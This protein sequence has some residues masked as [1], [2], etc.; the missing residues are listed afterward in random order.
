MRCARSL[1]NAAT[2]SHPKQKL[3]AQKSPT[4]RSRRLS[5]PK[6]HVERRSE[7]SLWK[8][9]QLGRLQFWTTAKAYPD[10]DRVVK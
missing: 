5:Q 8:D 1:R 3:D 6:I 7:S 4:R 10:P 2:T 9:P